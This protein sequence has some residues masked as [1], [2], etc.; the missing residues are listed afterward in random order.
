RLDPRPGRLLAQPHHRPLRVLIPIHVAARQ[1]PESST[2]LDVAPD[3]QHAAVA[4]DQSGHNYLR[5]AKED[6]LAARAEAQ[7]PC[8]D[9]LDLSPGPAVGAVVGQSV[10]RTRVATDSRSCIGLPIIRRGGMRPRGRPSRGLGRVFASWPSPRPRLRPQP[11]TPDVPVAPPG[12]GAPGPTP[13]NDSTPACGLLSPPPQSR[14]CTGGC[15]GR[16]ADT[17]GTPPCV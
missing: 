1:A 17:S 2:G 9:D 6:A 10:R 5:I 15:A 8:R 3:Q 13:S 7:R 16:R 12:S 4:L 11:R 14:P